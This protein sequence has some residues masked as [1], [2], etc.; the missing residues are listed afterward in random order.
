MYAALRLQNEINA[1]I[2]HAKTLYATAQHGN[3][4]SGSHHRVSFNTI[5]SGIISI[6]TYEMHICK[7]NLYFSIKENDGLV[8]VLMAYLYYKGSMSSTD[9]PVTCD[10]VSTGIPSCFI[11]LAFSLRSAARPSSLPS[12]RSV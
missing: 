5:H 6:I 3:D 10:I 2:L 1:H 4:I 9:N 12:S 11:F 8:F 7:Q